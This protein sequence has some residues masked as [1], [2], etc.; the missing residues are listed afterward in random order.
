MTYDKNRKPLTCL[1]AVLLVIAMTFSCA[2]TAAGEVTSSTDSISSGDASEEET[3]AS[4][5]ASGQNSGSDSSNDLSDTE[6]AEEE[7]EEEEETL[8]APSTVTISSASAGTDGSITVKWKKVSGATGYQ[9]YRSVNGG[10]YSK[11]KTISSASTVSWKNTSVS[12]GKIYRY[13]IRAYKVSSSGSQ[14]VYGSFSSVKKVTAKPAK[15]TIRSAKSAAALNAVTVKW[16]KVSGATGY[17]I[18]RSTDGGSYKKVKTITKASTVSWKDTTVKAGKTYRYKIRAYVKANGTTIYGSFSSVSKVKTVPGQ[19][20]ISKVSLKST[21]SAVLTWEK[22]SGASGYVIYRSTSKSGT[23]KRIATVSGGSKLTCT[24]TGVSA[25]KRYYYKV[26]AYRTVSGKKIYGSYSEIY[27]QPVRFI[28]VSQ[29]KK[30]DV[31]DETDKIIIVNAYST[32]SSN[33]V[34]QY[35][36]KTNGTWKEVLRVSG[37]IGKNGI[38]KTKEGD[39]KTPTG[40]YH[41]TKLFGIKSNPGTQ[42]SYTKLTSSMYWC[43]ELYYNQFVNDATNST[44]KKKCSHSNDEHLSTYTTVYNYCAA[45]DYNSEGT[46]GAGSAIFLHCKRSTSKYTAGCVAIDETSMKT[47]IKDIDEDTAI[48]IDQYT[49]IKKY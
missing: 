16:K 32:T 43:S 29:L 10:S 18:Y 2:F 11:V 26:R 12:P 7:E 31:A 8:T 20:T 37:V 34:V 35:F 25:T 5:N 42:M 1:F 38:N 36:K 22:V 48:V 41:F 13:K 30:M 33:A 44:H 47:I 40:V 6:D 14:T 21:T 49:K 28:S 23:Y 4:G 9:I 24:V 27:T 3:D 17:Q 39:K 15:V 46:D 19:V 45:L